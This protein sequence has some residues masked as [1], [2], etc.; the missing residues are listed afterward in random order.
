VGSSSLRPRQRKDKPKPASV[1]PFSHKQNFGGPKNVFVDISGNCACVEPSAQMPRLP[2][3]RRFLH[4]A[5]KLQQALP[6]RLCQLMDQGI[7]TDAQFQNAM[8]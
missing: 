1:P 3:D 7:G 6:R 8:R 2:T 4:S 5:C